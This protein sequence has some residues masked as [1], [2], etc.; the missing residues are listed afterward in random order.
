VYIKNNVDISDTLL[1][2]E[3]QY[4]KWSQSETTKVQQYLKKYILGDRL[5]SK[6]LHMYKIVQ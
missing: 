1:C 4:T 6:F 5:P 2:L 3:R